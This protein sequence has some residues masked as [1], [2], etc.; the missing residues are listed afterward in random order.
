MAATVAWISRMRQALA[1]NGTLV[2]MVVAATLDDSFKQR[3]FE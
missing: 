3:A 2:D 1:G